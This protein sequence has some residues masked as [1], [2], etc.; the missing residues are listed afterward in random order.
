MTIETIADV[1]VK[2]VPETIGE[3]MITVRTTVTITIMILPGNRN[4]AMAVVAGTMELLGPTTAVQNAQ[5]GART[6]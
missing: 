3:M 6:V 4:R 5:P 2:T 1:A